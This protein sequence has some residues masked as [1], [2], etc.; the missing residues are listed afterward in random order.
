MARESR[1]WAPRRPSSSGRPASI[2]R[3]CAAVVPMRFLRL[4][5]RVSGRPRR[6]SLPTAPPRL[7]E[8]YLGRVSEPASRASTLAMCGRLSSHTRTC[9]NSDRGGAT[10]YHRS[11]PS[12]T[13]TPESESPGRQL[14]RRRGESNPCTGLCRPCADA[15]KVL[16]D[17]H[18][19]GAG[20][21]VGREVDAAQ[22]ASSLAL[23]VAIG[24]TACPPRVP[25]V[26]R[27]EFAEGPTPVMCAGWP[28]VRLT[29]RAVSRLVG[30]GRGQA[31]RERAS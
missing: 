25:T 31:A 29:E 8:T 23:A 30:L 15:M 9:I 6:H 1:P 14:R 7:G 28:T 13:Q 26:E 10:D 5:S 17:G 19:E 12:Q 18:V 27:T 4:V 21:A 11:P 3:R 20:D 2:P 16:V 24:H 22:R